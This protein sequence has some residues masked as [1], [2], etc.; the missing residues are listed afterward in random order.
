MSLALVPVARIHLPSDAFAIHDS[1][2]CNGDIA[3]ALR[4]DHILS[5]N[6][7][8]YNLLRSANHQVGLVN[9]RLTVTVH[10]LL[11]S[12]RKRQI[13]NEGQESE[14]PTN[15]SRYDSVT[16][17]PRLITTSN[18]G[19]VLA[20][21]V[22]ELIDTQRL[23]CELKLS[24]SNQNHGVVRSDERLADAVILCRWYR[25]GLTGIISTMGS[26][27]SQV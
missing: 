6:E 7:A 12:S 24:N 26:L 14:P 22:E 16:Y 1:A 13:D 4:C 11:K 10:H 17:G 21:L 9:L 8:T 19:K 27:Q 25:N 20:R 2:K 3:K 15:E 23:S 18:G 5:P